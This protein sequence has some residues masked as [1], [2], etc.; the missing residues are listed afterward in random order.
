M[1][2]GGHRP[3][4]TDSR[5][6]SSE[7][8][9]RYAW[10]VAATSLLL[11]ATAGGAL[12]LV[13]AVLVPRAPEFG[14]GR[15]AITLTYSA[16]MLGAGLGGIWM[17]RWLDR[18]GVFPPAVL[19]ASMIAAGAWAASLTDNL[20][21]WLLAYGFAIGLFGV[22]AFISPLLANATRW[23]ERH[24]GL[25][26]SMVA[27][28]QALA[29]TV[30]PPVFSYLDTRYGWQ[31]TFQA[32]AAFSFAVMVPLC[33]VLRRPAP[34]LAITPGEAARSVDDAQ[35]L[36]FTPSGALAVLCTAIIGCCVA[37]SMPLVHFPA[38]AIE[39]GFSVQRGALMLSVLM[40]TS[41]LSRV[42]WG[43][44]C[45]RIGGLPTLF[46]TSSLQALALGAMALVHSEAGLFAVAIL[47]GLGFGGIIPCYPVII[48]EYF[49]LSGLGWRVGMVVLFGTIGMAV[50][51]PLAGVVHEFVGAYPPGFAIGVAFNA[52]NLA[53]VGMLNLRKRRLH[54]AALAA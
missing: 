24:R 4:E 49:P 43:A 1:P 45:D 14:Y 21:L 38:Y 25:A 30:W 50:G 40:F 27:T 31:A 12:F 34:R 35:V 28:G 6:A 23:F 3:S 15:G 47:F 9:S 26:V 36:G 51:P 13:S 11:A 2:Q 17:G 44:V 32:F 29:G 46:A 48:R 19:G 20:W 10:L 42:S 54:G 8:D 7:L 41:M 52:M 16:A 33:F 22:A 39:L 5:S 18:A 37:M 53:L